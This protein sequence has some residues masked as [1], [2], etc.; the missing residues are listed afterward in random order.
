MPFPTSIVHPSGAKLSLVPDKVLVKV[1]HAEGARALADAADPLAELGL[2]PLTLEPPRA[3]AGSPVAGGLPDVDPH[4]L[5]IATVP[6]RFAALGD[7]HA[8][9]D[10]AVWS[11]EPLLEWAARDS[12]E[13]PDEQ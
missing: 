10:D 4:D 11:S 13:V 1:A 12:L 7:L 9:I 5:T 6:A 8:G 3:A 2:E